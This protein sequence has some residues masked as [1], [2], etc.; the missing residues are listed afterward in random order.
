VIRWVKQRPMYLTVFMLFGLAVLAC[1]MEDR[2]VRSSEQDRSGP[3]I[4]Q[5]V[6]GRVTTSDGRSLRGAFIQ[7]RSLDDP[8]PPIP[9]I[10][11]L[12]DSDGRYTWPLFPGTYEISVSLKGCQRAIR[13]V[14]VG[15][16]QV[17][18]A[19]FILQCEPYH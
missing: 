14:V 10:A 17:V 19:D 1:E 18:K 8:S 11:I 4:Q 15:A 6:A 5:G 13:Q 3:H 7:P 12:T 9:E 2:P 16:G